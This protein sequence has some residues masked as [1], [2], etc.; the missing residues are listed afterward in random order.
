M[1]PYFSKKLRRTIPKEINEATKAAIARAVPAL[2][3]STTVR[4]PE[5]AA[6]ADLTPPDAAGILAIP[7]GPAGPTCGAGPT[8]GNG[9]LA[10]AGRATVAPAPA[11]LEPAPAGRG[12]KEIRMVSL[13]KS[14]GGLAIPGT[15]GTDDASP[16]AAGTEGTTGFRA[17]GMAGTGGFGNV[18]M[19][20]A[21][22]PGGFG[23]AG[24]LGKVG[25]GGGAS[26]IVSFFNPGGGGTDGVGGLEIGGVG[27]A[28]TGGL[29]V[30][31]LGGWGGLTT[32]GK[33]GDPGDFG[34]KGTPSAI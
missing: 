4:T 9:G 17:P 8:P 31:K 33:G 10:A 24:P 23:R 12:G 26:L 22:G 30:G 6:T 21:T 25:F 2:S 29:L 7:D 32:L 13:R 28:A 5:D 3:V 11:V 1:S 16:V 19:P 15:A 18:E 34:G 20:G 27:N 14:D